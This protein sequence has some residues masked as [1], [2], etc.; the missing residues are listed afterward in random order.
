[1][2]NVQCP[3]ANVQCP[4]ANVQ[5]PMSDT[6]WQKDEGVEN[7]EISKPS[8]GGLTGHSIL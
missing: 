3:M 5:C 2:A 8:P 7:E 1:M 6:R 4:M